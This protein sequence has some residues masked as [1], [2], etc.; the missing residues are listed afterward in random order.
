MAVVG[1]LQINHPAEGAAGG[2]ALH[3]QVETNFTKISDNV[4]HRYASFSGVL[5]G[6]TFAVAHNLGVNLSE[7][8]VFIYS[9]TH[10]TLTAIN[11]P[12]NLV[13]PWAIAETSGSETTSLDITAPASGGPFTGAVFIVHAKGAEVKA[14]RV[15][16]AISAA[17]T[18]SNKRIHLV[19]SSGGAFA[20]TLPAPSAD[21]FIVVKDSDG[22]ASVENI[23]INTPGAET[24]DGLASYVLATNYESVTIV[25]DGTN[26]FIV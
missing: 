14:A 4:L 18:L 7:L 11:D 3:A 23:T 20:V 5:D 16:R 1:R 17:A 24:I 2:P 12:E 15:N 9:G 22:S 21:L 26:Y 10:P 8:E 6:A 19:D 25:S 13:V